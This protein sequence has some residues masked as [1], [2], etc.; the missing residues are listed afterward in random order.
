M[1]TSAGLIDASV[2]ESSPYV[3]STGSASTPAYSAADSMNRWRA[4]SFCPSEPEATRAVA[5]PLSLETAKRL[6]EQDETRTFANE[7][8]REPHAL[9]LPTGDPHATF[10]Q[11]RLHSLGKTLE[12][13]REVGAGHR[14]R[15][16]VERL[17]RFPED[18]V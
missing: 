5:P 11:V 18:D 4:R 13:L 17:A 15:Q 16:P 7:G 6:V 8:S 10:A 2:V 3:H 9:P 14:L 1:R 12:N